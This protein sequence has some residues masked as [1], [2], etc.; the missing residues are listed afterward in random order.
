MIRAAS[1]ALVAIVLPACALLLSAA[2]C[3]SSASNGGGGSDGGVD[4]PDFADSDDPSY[5]GADTVPQQFYESVEGL[6][7]RVELPSGVS[8]SPASLRVVTTAGETQVGSDGSVTPKLQNFGS[9]LTEVVD[10]SGNIV[11]YGYVQAAGATPPPIN[12]RSTAVV[13]LYFALGSWALPDKLARG[14]VIRELEVSHD[15]IVDDLAAV[16][17]QAMRG[18][19]EAIQDA[20]AS[21]LAAVST[22]KQAILASDAAGSAKSAQRAGELSPKAQ[23]GTA[24][25]A[26]FVSTD[27]D[28]TVGQ[29][30]IYLRTSYSSSG[31]VPLNRFR[32]Q[33]KLYA[34]LTGT[35]SGDGVLTTLDPIEY[36][37]GPIDITPAGGYSAESGLVSRLASGDSNWD[38][39]KSSQFFLTGDGTDS[40]ADDS[41]IPDGGDTAVS[42]FDVVVLGPALDGPAVPP[43]LDE[44]RFTE[45]R[46]EF[47]AVID[48]LEWK[49]FLL[50]YV[51]PLIDEVGIGE[52]TYTPTVTTDA[53]IA[54]LRALVEPLIAAQGITIRT[55]EG[56]QDAMVL[57]LDAFKTDTAFRNGYL[58]IMKR[59]LGSANNSLNYNEVNKRAVRALLSALSGIIITE[60]VKAPDV[61]FV[62]SHLQRSHEADLWR[63]TLRKVVIYPG[64]PE[65]TKQATRIRLAAKVATSDRSLCYEWSSPSGYGYISEIQG[66]QTGPTFL[67]NEGAVSYTSTPN[68]INNNDLDPVTVTV[69]DV[70]DEPDASANCALN[71]G[72]GVSLGADTV[73]VYGD[74]EEHTCEGLDLSLY[75]NGPLTMT[76]SPG[77]VL[78]GDE[79]TV[80]LSYDF[81]QTDGGTAQVYLYLPFA[82]SNCATGE[83]ICGAE[84]LDG[85]L[86]DGG[87]TAPY[88]V[89]Q[90]FGVTSGIGGDPS[91]SVPGLSTACAWQL[92]PIFTLP[93]PDVKEV[94]THQFTY[95]FNRHNYPR[96][97]GLGP[98]CAS[99]IPDPYSPLDMVWYGNWVVARTIGIGPNGIAAQLLDIGEDPTFEFGVND[100]CDE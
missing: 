39:T 15:E 100:P 2:G 78:P 87:A 76:V 29:S 72:L 97:P 16:I 1:F 18:N 27:P 31:I 32:R 63:V 35:E 46:S 65:V 20:D 40:Q 53:R 89:D 22:A 6:A 43:L 26:G 45:Q 49:T 62:Y 86:Y 56:Y 84:E 37:T 14:E 41:G 61:S 98:V 8:L 30:G 17:E 51:V 44:P 60:G 66:T 13:L 82:C 12:A 34:Y 4:I 21:I 57:C 7:T 10:G 25:A 99:L 28:R 92:A 96:K 70:T 38:S 24:A 90:T 9:L 69:Y 71:A 55:T 42:H 5:D 52:A 59:S 54:A 48:E 11:L 3:Q 19:P 50:D 83:C 79:V 95:V 94:I 73:T 91:Q 33:A 64:E 23:A 74:G 58:S 81:A 85:L 77:R 36:A 47:L 93:D 67:S 88:N 68:Q 75:N 80:T